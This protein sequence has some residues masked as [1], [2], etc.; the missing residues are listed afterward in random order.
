LKK[1]LKTLDATPPKEIYR[2]IIVDYDL[3][4]GICELADNAID[5]WTK[6]GSTNQLDININLD[7][8]QQKI[9][10]IDNAGGIGENN[11]LDFI[12]PGRTGNTAQEETIGIFGVGS[13]RAVVALAQGNQNDLKKG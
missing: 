6:K 4:L 5:I 3:K 12:S 8:D 7:T 11:I 1:P 13:K 9:T 10:I 2:S